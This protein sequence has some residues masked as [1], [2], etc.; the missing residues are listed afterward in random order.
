MRCISFAAEI[1]RSEL[2]ER[3]YAVALVTLCHCCSA[4]WT[5]VQQQH[6]RLRKR[7]FILTNVLLFLFSYIF[8]VTLSGNIS[9]SLPLYR[10]H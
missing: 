5:H 4:D 10:D 3:S 9:S 1:K 7:N 6:L 8:I 2:G